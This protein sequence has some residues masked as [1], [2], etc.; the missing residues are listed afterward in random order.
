MANNLDSNITRKLARSFLEPFEIERVLSKNV[1]TQFISGS[2]NASS[3]KTIDIK[4]PTDFVSSRTA[5]G[6]ISGGVRS[7]IVT[8]KASAVVQDMFTVSV[9]YDQVEEAIKLDQLDQLLAPAARRIVTDYEVDFGN[10]M[11]KNTG[12]LAGSVGTAVTTWDHVAEAG[13]ILDASGVPHDKAWNYA[14]NPFTQRKLASGQR[15]LGT[16]T[17]SLTANDRAL[18]DPNFAGMAVRTSNALGNYTTHSVAD[19]AGTISAIDVTYVTHKD[20][21]I[22]SVTVAAMGA[23]LQVRAGETLVFAAVNRVNLSTRQPIVDET[24]ANVLFS[25]TVTEDVTLSGTGTGVIKITGPAIF[26]SG[27]AYNTTDVAAANGGV[28]TLQGAVSTL[29]QPN[30]FWHPSAFAIGSVGLS[31]LHSTDTLATTEDG[32]QIRVSKGTSF[33]GRQADCTLRLPTCLWCA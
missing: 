26:E 4:R 19:R 18:L 15:P 17:L 6:D 16:D 2:Y 27:G 22:Q 3:G 13:S 24:G 25:G 32:L 31:K 1:N 9:D 7:P 8:G 29:I 12:L 23:N 20:T 5:A 30:L 21:M 14:V 10:F 11:L 33:F 28:V